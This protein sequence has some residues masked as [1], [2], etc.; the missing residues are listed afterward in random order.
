MT[1]LMI[2][3]AVSVFVMVVIAVCS[4]RHQFTFQISF[5]CLVRIAFRAGTESDPCFFQR[6]LRAAAYSAADQHVNRLIGQKSCK[7]AVSHAVGTDYFTGDY[8]TVFYFIYLEKLCPSKMLKNVS[9]L[10]SYCY[11]HFIFPAFCLLSN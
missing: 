11:F 8:L 1:I 7:G 2:A 5:Y 10:I 3:A 4:G 6:C 9:I